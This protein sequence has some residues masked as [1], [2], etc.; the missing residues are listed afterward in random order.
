MSATNKKRMSVQQLWKLGHEL[1]S[2]RSTPDNDTKQHAWHSFETIEQHHTARWTNQPYNFELSEKFDAFLNTAECKALRSWFNTAPA[3]GIGAANEAARAAHA[4]T[5]EGALAAKLAAKANRKAQLA[6]RAK[7]YDPET[8]RYGEPDGRAARD[9]LASEQLRRNDRNNNDPESENAEGTEFK[10]WVV[11]EQYDPETGDYEELDG[12][13][14]SLASFDDDQDAWNYAENV[15]HQPGHAELLAAAREL[16]N[17]ELGMGPL[18]KEFVAAF[19]RLYRAVK[20][21][22]NR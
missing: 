9:Q 2:G 7:L 18:S 14:S 8:G 10:V 15:A 3:D 17:A 12:P 13:G 4:D 5:L 19:Q 21:V 20:S 1:I 11:I 22:D 6:A 16:T